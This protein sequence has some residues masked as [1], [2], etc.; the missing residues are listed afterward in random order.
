MRCEDCECEIDPI[1]LEYLP[2]TK[3]CKSCSDK[4]TPKAVCRMIYP[5]KTGGELFV[6][7]GD[8]NIRRLNN[9]YRRAR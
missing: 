8:E 1:R 7:Y 5:H 9:E 2:D 3:W 4:H 6:A